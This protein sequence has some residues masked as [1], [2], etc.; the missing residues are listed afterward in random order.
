VT[1]RLT[2]REVA[3]RLRLSPETVLRWARRGD[4]DGV[5][6]RLSS[7]AIRFREDELEAWLAARAKGADTVPTSAPAPLPT[8]GRVTHP[9]GTLE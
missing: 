4:F 2:T 9:R 3:E 5:V 6:E 8:A 1:G 7:R